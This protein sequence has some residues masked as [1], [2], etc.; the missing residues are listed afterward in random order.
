MDT[1][2]SKPQYSHGGV[3][4]PKFPRVSVTIGW[5]FVAIL[6]L[7]V[8]QTL[9]PNPLMRQEWSIRVASSFLPLATSIVLARAYYLMHKWRRRTESV[10]LLIIGLLLVG[11]M[12]TARADVLRDPAG[13]LAQF[14]GASLGAFFIWRPAVFLLKRDT[15]AFYSDSEAAPQPEREMI[16]RQAVFGMLWPIVILVLLFAFAYIISERR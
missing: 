4:P 14:I 3:V 11:Y 5:I 9:F 10:S 15:K 7:A 8:L 13:F 1:I 16:T 12:V 2:Q 6:V